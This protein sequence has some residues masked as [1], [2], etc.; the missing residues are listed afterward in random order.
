MQN[1]YLCLHIIVRSIIASVPTS[2]D[3]QS[4][5]NGLG[6]TICF[7]GRNNSL[8]GDLKGKL[9]NS[10]MRCKPLSQASIDLLSA[11]D[12]AVDSW[13]HEMTNKFHPLYQTFP[14]KQDRNRLLMPFAFMKL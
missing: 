4:Q 6:C 12:D 7:L 14:E 10:D 3:S 13:L 8:I 9:Q 11:S 1:I 5:V 2:K